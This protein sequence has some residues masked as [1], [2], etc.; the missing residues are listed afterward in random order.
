[1]PDISVQI[2]GGVH[3][4]ARDILLLQQWEYVSEPTSPVHIRIFTLVT[5]LNEPCEHNH[6]TRRHGGDPRSPENRAGPD[7]RSLPTSSGQ[8]FENLRTRGRHWLSGP[9]LFKHGLTSNLAVYLSK[10]STGRERAV[11]LPKNSKCTLTVSNDAFGGL[12]Y[13]VG[14]PSA[15]KMARQRSG[16][17]WTRIRHELGALLLR[18]RVLTLGHALE[19]VLADLPPRS[20]SCVSTWMRPGPNG[21]PGTQKGPK[22]LLLSPW[23][24]ELGLN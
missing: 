8:I 1:M 13:R 24:T 5:L 21:R 3:D 12:W 18:F 10:S 17:P 9:V 15:S 19:V 11:L 7:Q 4:T 22:L 14:P 20:S 23:R 16:T 2:S 6:G